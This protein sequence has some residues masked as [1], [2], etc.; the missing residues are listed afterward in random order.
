MS[1]SDGMR[2]R[3]REREKER[4]RERKKERER[5]RESVCVCVCDLIGNRLK[6]TYSDILAF[7][8]EKSLQKTVGALTDAR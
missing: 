5:E 2:E 7:P 8:V 1:E 4:E 6:E 3:E